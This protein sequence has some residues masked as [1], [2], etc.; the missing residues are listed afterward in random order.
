MGSICG[1]FWSLYFRSKLRR[2]EGDR[3][4]VCEPIDQDRGKHMELHGRGRVVNIQPFDSARAFLDKVGDYL[5]RNEAGNNL[6]LGL[7]SELAQEKRSDKATRSVMVVAERAEGGEPVLI[8]LLTPLNLIVAGAAQSPPELEQAVRLM[9]DHLHASGAEVPGVVG[10]PDLAGAFA[11]AWASVAGKT[12]FVK[13]NQRIYRLDE[14]NPVPYSPGDLRLA[15]PG[16]LALVADWIHEFAESI[17]ENLGREEAAAKAREN[18]IGGSLYIWDDGGPVSMAKKTR[19]T[20]HGIVLSLVYTPPG[21]RNQGYASSC[22]AA[23]SKLLLG[24]GYRFCSLY[25]DLSNPTSNAIY[26]RIGYKPVQDSILYRF[27]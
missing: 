3:H 8:C 13:M 24:E 27:R 15:G 22:V 1:M 23:L 4:D 21:R 18:L 2:E 17:G 20:R 12:A 6:L 7:L 9:T 14:V 26:A 11:D 5:E 25:T 16:D 19:P 10:P